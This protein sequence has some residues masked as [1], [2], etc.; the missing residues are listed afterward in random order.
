MDNN[1]I[2]IIDNIIKI[3][4]V[5]FNDNI[6][7]NT[8]QSNMDTFYDFVDYFFDNVFMKN[9]FEHIKKNN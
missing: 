6:V 7:I 4:P 8:L 1:Y 9:Y 5:A 3:K 2:D